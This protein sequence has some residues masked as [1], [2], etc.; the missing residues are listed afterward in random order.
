MGFSRKKYWS[1]LPFPP[2]GDLLNP[3]IEP[4]SPESPA[5]PGRFFTTEP[6]RKS[7]SMS[8]ILS[9]LVLLLESY[10]TLHVF[11]P[12]WSIK[13]WGKST[14][15]TYYKGRFL[16]FFFL[17][18]LSILALYFEGIFNIFLGIS[19][20][21]LLQ[22][23]TFIIYSLKTDWILMQ[24]YYLLLLLFSCY[25]LISL[26]FKPFCVLIFFH[27]KTALLKE[28]YAVKWGMTF[29]SLITFN[30]HVCPY[31]PT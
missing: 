14:E 26:D 24:L 12:V 31:N 7:L 16:Y 19:N 18:V 30:L 25:L 29:K 20:T 22:N 15:M 23:I 27:S 8:I 3:R 2:P 13:P 4:A 9:L 17:L 28:V 21:L 11:L 10:I 1:R 5:W 6:L